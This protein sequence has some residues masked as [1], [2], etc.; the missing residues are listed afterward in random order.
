MVPEADGKKPEKRAEQH[1]AL[2]ASVLEPL[3]LRYLKASDVDQGKFQDRARKLRADKVAGIVERS[4]RGSFHLEVNVSRA[5]PIYATSSLYRISLVSC[6]ELTF[7]T[8]L[9]RPRA[10][11]GQPRSK[12]ILSRRW[13]PALLR[14]RG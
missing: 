7:P 2:L 13:E 11:V 14:D 3:F 6:I 9:A 12:S 8:E 1:E 10:K 5:P 4:K